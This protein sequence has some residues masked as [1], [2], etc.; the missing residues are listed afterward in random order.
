MRLLLKKWVKEY[1][2][3]VDSILRRKARNIVMWYY[4]LEDILTKCVRRKLHNFRRRGK[5]IKKI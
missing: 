1:L 4:E 5:D 2:E 3:D